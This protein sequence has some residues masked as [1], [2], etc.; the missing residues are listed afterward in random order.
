MTPFQQTGDPMIAF[1]EAACVPMDGRGHREGTL[2]EANAI[3][4]RNP[5]VAHASIYTAAI[6]AD[7]ATVRACLASDADEAVRKGGPRAWDA[8]TYL[9]FSRYLRLD[10]SRSDAFVKTARALLEA[11]ASANTGWYDTIDKDTQ[12]RQIVEAAIYGA[13]GVA[14]HSGVTRLLLEH[15]ADPND[16]ETPYHVPE[17]YDNSVLAILLE[18]GTLNERSLGCILVRKADWHDLDGLRLA[19][20]HGAN[21]AVSPGWQTYPLHHAIDRDNG[22]EAVTALLDHGADPTVTR[23]KD[24]RSALQLAVH[25]GRGDI[26]MLLESRG[27]PLSLAGVERLIAACAMDDRRAIARHLEETPALRGALLERSGQLLA[28]FSGVG[29]ARGIAAL[30]DC[31]APV[32]SLYRGDPYFDIASNS[33]ALHVAAWRASHDVVRLLI[34]RGA[35]VNAHDGRGRT[36]LMLAVKAC[37]DSHWMADRAPA[38]VR[39]LL[40]AGASVVGVAVP[41]GYDEVDALLTA[42]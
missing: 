34:S 13:A 29:N 9:C 12:P 8:V 31:G 16:E 38:S 26:L 20:A 36:A 37:L 42:R 27:V 35:S 23:P 33:T 32:D 11:G 6:L 39:A 7:E 14:R 25:R 40:E 21:P 2:D 1:V 15:G 24:E 22:I 3:L 28:E 18:S 4:E 30:L 10:R 41:C 17:T 5:D 19:L